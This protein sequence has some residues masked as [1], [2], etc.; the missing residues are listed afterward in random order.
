MTN[1]LKH[2]FALTLAIMILSIWITTIFFISNYHSSEKD[3]IIISFPKLSK[4]QSMKILFD[5]DVKIVSD[6]GKRYGID[7]KIWVV[8]GIRENLL[9]SMKHEKTLILSFIQSLSFS[10][11]GGCFF[12]S[13]L[14]KNHTT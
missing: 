6:F 7:G 1:N 11:A 14:E 4:E 5:S 12:F 8:Y 10:S 13:Y 3:F 2:S 9:N